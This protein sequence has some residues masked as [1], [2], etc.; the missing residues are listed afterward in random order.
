MWVFLVE[1]NRCLPLWHQRRIPRLEEANGGLDRF[2]ANPPLSDAVLAPRTASG[3]SGFGVLRK[4]S[5]FTFA[6]GFHWVSAG[7]MLPEQ[8][9]KWSEKCQN[10]VPEAI[11][12]LLNIPL[13]GVSWYNS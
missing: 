12:G 2:H 13:R 11:F 4:D 7:L 9:G 6:C 1:R 8:S 10:R 3:H 5:Y